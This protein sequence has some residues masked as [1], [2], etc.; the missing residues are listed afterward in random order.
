MSLT[1][2]SVK[3]Q[4]FKI[5]LSHQ[6]KSFK[7][8]DAELQVQQQPTPPVDIDDA[9]RAFDFRD[10]DFIPR[11]DAFEQVEWPASSGQ[12][13]FVC[14]L[15]HGRTERGLSVILDPW[16]YGFTGGSTAELRAKWFDN[17]DVDYEACA[18]LPVFMKLAFPG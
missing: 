8:R 6:M 18:F 14:P 17:F 10:V 5:D 16:L 12:F 7:F 4:L 11:H 2:F 9:I 1:A 13:P 3:R 15:W